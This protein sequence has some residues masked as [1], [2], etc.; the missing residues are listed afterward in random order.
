MTQPAAEN[1]STVLPTPHNHH[2]LLFWEQSTKKCG[3]IV[4]EMCPSS[5]CVNEMESMNLPEMWAADHLIK[6]TIIS[7]N[8]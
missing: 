2:T 1:F 5:P 8:N 4:Q 7:A 3:C 6:Q